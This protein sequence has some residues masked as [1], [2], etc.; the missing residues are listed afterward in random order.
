MAFPESWMNEL[1]AKNDIVTVISSYMEL[2]PKGRR[3]WGLCP[4]HGE[5]TPSFSVSQ[6]KQMFY[7][8]GCHAG[9]TVIQFIMDM[10]RLS[11]LE[12]V[13]FLADRAGVQMPEEVDDRRMQ[14]ER[15]YRDRMY[16]ACKM[17]ARFYMEML[18]G[19]EGNPGR[20]YLKD[21]GITSEAV[22]RFGIGYAPDSWDAL[23]RYLFNKGFTQ[24]ELL[25]AGLLM[26][27]VQ[28]DRVYDAYRGRVIYPIVGTNGRVLGFG[29]RVLNNDKPKYINTGDTP[30]YNKRMNL[31]GLNLQKGAQ[32][33]DLVIVEGYMDVIGLHQAGVAN[34]V[35]SL[36][37][38]LTIQQA[39]LIK[40]YVTTVFIAYDGDAAGQNAMIRGLD[41][42]SG[43]GLSVR[44][45][46]FPNGQ[47]PDE[48]VRTHGKE[49]FEALKDRA[50]SLNAY[51]IESM[52]HGFELS[53]E[54]AREQFAR[55]TC[56]FIASLEP[57]E[58][59]RYYQQLAQKTGYPMAALKAQGS[60]SKPLEQSP[61]NRSVPGWKNNQNIARLDETE[62]TRAETTLLYAMLQDKMSA[63]AAAEQN[64]AAL[65]SQNAFVLLANAIIAASAAGLEPNA[66]TMIAGMDKPDADLASMVL[67]E[68]MILTE[69][70]QVVNDCIRRIRRYDLTV[71]IQEMTQAVSEIGIT[72]EE[73]TRRLTEIQQTN[74][75][76][77]GI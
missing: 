58:Q 21:R 11:F 1:I 62:R 44:V 5:K 27:N 53:N 70:V 16:D 31:Y 25:D 18:L 56:R 30:I 15:A 47:D 72:P 17:A 7:C 60:T 57:I 33:T 13:K 3:L 77:R 76:M 69:P 4:L 40:R 43:E 54:N 75:E 68:D 28:S 65:F 24:Q 42:L 23:M 39:R 46:V 51:K 20:K 36:G 73:R 34:V 64:V 52:S 9:G 29:A 50:L 59:D 2:K 63:K 66:A 67:R 55:E 41:I 35:A 37:T 26:K 12:A 45:I 61:L 14:Q 8:F 38:A 10:E 6:D 49:A 32:L 19:P 22:K 74:R 48:F 71:R